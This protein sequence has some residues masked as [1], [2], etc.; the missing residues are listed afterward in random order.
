MEAAHEHRQHY[1][2]TFAMLAMAAIVYALLQ[3]LVAPALPAIQADL[4]A[5]ATGATWILTAKA[6]GGTG[7][8]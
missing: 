3:S 7:L 1:G 2:I 8:P 6:A 5:S 4:H